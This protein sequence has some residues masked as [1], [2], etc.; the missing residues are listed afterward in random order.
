MKAQG[1][2]KTVTV[3][4]MLLLLTVVA[5]RGPVNAEPTD[6][7]LGRGPGAPV[8]AAS[9]ETVVSCPFRSTAGNDGLSRG[10]YVVDYPGINLGTVQVIYRTDDAGSYHLSM[11]ARAGAYDG[12]P[13]GQTQ[14][15]TVDLPAST[16]I[17]ATFDFGGAPVTPGTTVTFSQEQVSGPGDVYY[18]T[19]P[20]SFNLECT[21]CPDVYQTYHT[22]PP[23]DTVRRRSV[24][25]TIT[26][27]AAPHSLYLPVVTR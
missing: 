9:Q 11:T 12:A 4:S 20:C 21:L 13:I 1:I 18:N 23:L 2:R 10:F 8:P 7:G 25:V 26:Q 15:I 16:Y 22:E 19:G 27:V 6:G 24:A 14:V 17:T 5:P 3:V